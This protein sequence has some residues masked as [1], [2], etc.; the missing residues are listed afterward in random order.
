M[1][2]ATK[3]LRKC[4]RARAHAHT[5]SHTFHRFAFYISLKYNNFVTTFIRYKEIK[6]I[7]NAQKLKQF[8]IK[9]IE[10]FSIVYFFNII[11]FI[12]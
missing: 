4:A 8:K 6:H 12:Y 7:N 5:H 10:N 3:I 11:F 2:M 1:K 9:L